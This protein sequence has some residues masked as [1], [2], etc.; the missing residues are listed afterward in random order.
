[1]PVMRMA[2]ELAALRKENTELREAAMRYGGLEETLGHVR[3]VL[4][5]KEGSSCEYAETALEAARRVM[6]DLE[7]AKG[8][9][10]RAVKEIAG[11][12]CTI[13]RLERL[14]EGER[15]EREK[16]ETKARELK[17]KLVAAEQ[18][19]IETNKQLRAHQAT[20]ERLDGIA[21]EQGETICRLNAQLESAR[22]ELNLWR[23]DYRHPHAGGDP[24]SIK[25]K[26]DADLEDFTRKIAEAREQLD[27]LAKRAREDFAGI[28]A[29]RKT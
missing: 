1:M 14:A 25:V 2:D 26:V 10:E 21:K 12:G 23:R 13:E 8:Q 5:A 27:L 15:D 18:A 17:D 24:G 6:R 7:T 16:W 9:D 20:A 11:Q 4:Q 3:L 29:W 22:G 28:C 19:V